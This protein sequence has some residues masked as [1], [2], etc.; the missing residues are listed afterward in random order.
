M[1]HLPT[2]AVAQRTSL[3]RVGTPAA[4]SDL[5][6]NPAAGRYTAHLKGLCSPSKADDATPQKSSEARQAE[7]KSF[8]EVRL[9]TN[10][11][12]FRGFVLSEALSDDRKRLIA[13]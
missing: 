12:F 4:Y 1:R 11:R 6:F 8:F 2:Q 3:V 13:A 7:Q 9:L 5:L 10:P